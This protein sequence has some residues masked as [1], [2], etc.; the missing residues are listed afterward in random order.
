M[1]NL[2]IGMYNNRI[3][4]QEKYIKFKMTGLSTGAEVV[5]LPLKEISTITPVIEFGKSG[6]TVVPRTMDVR[7]SI[8]TDNTVSTTE[9]QEKVYRIMLPA[10]AND[11]AAV[12]VAINEFADFVDL[13]IRSNHAVTPIEHGT[14]THKPTFCVQT[15]AKVNTLFT[16]AG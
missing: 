4:V 5:L 16:P 12:S 15:E 6:N 13:C 8:V 11:A 2:D 3:P 7:T 9:P 14:F 1:S 10:T